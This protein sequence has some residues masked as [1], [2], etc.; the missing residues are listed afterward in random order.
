MMRKGFLSENGPPPAAGS[1]V[2]RQ[3]V[4]QREGF[5]KTEHCIA[6]HGTATHYKRNAKHCNAAHPST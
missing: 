4:A 3:V 6:L 5:E 2:G 1:Q